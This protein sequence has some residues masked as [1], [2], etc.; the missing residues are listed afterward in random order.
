MIS[1]ACT[2]INLKDIVMCSF[3]LGKTE[4]ELL[5]FLFHEE[6]QLTIQEIATKRGLER[7]TVQKAIAKLLAKG[8]VERRQLNLSSGGYRF[9]YAVVDKEN[10]KVELRQIVNGWHKNVN[11]AIK[12][13]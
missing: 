3:E 13:W 8:L 7:S 9:I 2:T 5:D 12:K 1:F 4:Y 6:E 11:E 10:I